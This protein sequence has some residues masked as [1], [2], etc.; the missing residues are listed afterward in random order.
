MLFSLALSLALPAPTPTP[1]PI[2]ALQS[3]ERLLAEAQGEVQTAAMEVVELKQQVHDLQEQLRDSACSPSPPPPSPPLPSPPPPSPPP[4]SPP[5]PSPTPAPPPPAPPPPLSP[6]PSSPAVCP[7]VA[8]CTRSR[9]EGGCHSNGSQC[10]LCDD[11]HE[12]DK[13]FN[14]I[15][16]GIIRY[17]EYGFLQQSSFIFQWHLWRHHITEALEHR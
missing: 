5:P 15:P 12:E 17:P 11:Q 10:R 13:C 1:M 8:G 4:P 9:L 14:D 2:P 6:P 3:I 7:F 16:Q